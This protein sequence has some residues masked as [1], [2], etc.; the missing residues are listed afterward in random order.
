MN[1]DQPAANNGDHIG[2]TAHFGSFSRGEHNS[3]QSH[4]TL[5]GARNSRPL[6]IGGQHG[7]KTTF[8][9]RAL[10][11]AL[12]LGGSGLKSQWERMPVGAT[13]FINPLALALP[14]SLLQIYDRIL[15]ADGA[16]TLTLRALLGR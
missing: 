12:C 11:C 7:G 2:D 3:L 1:R 13:V 9:R 4:D 6:D 16:S 10:S 8:Q 15:P 5:T 14:L